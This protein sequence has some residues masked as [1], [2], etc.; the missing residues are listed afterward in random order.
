MDGWMSSVVVAVYVVVVLN[1]NQ[2]LECELV[3][4]NVNVDLQKIYIK[5]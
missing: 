4:D 5:S 3:D 2:V 1:L